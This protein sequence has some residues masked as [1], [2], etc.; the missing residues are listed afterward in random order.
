MPFINKEYLAKIG[1]DKLVAPA[2]VITIMQHP[3]DGSFIVIITRKGK[4]AT[5]ASRVM[6]ENLEDILE[7][8]KGF[9][10]KITTESSEKDSSDTKP[11]PKATIGFTN[12]L[13][14][15]A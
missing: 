2:D 3:E 10:P 9:F 4:L 1:A 7:F 6:F 13:A 15:A 8:E 14:K 5:E 12:G 11:E